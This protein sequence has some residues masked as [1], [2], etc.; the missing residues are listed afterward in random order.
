[1]RGLPNR[2][3]I[4]LSFIFSVSF[5]EVTL[6]QE[7][8]DLDSLMRYYLRSDSI[9]L[10]ELERLTSDSLSIL[11]LIDSLLAYEVRFSQISA[12]FGYTSRI[13]NA[14]RDL[15]INQ[16]GFR[17]AL[18]Y[19]HKSGLLG[20][21]SAFWNSDVTPK[22]NPVITT[23]GYL[24]SIQSKFSYILSYDHFFYS[25]GSSQSDQSI[26]Y[27]FNNALNGSV[28][29]DLKYV[30]PGVD[31]SF[32]FGEETAHRFGTY[33]TGNIRFKNLS[34]GGISVLPTASL[35]F[36]NQTIYYQNINFQALRIA[37]Q[38]A[39]R[40]GLT[41]NDFDQWRQYV[42][43]EGQE[44]V[45]GLMNLSLSLPVYIHLEKVNLL[46]NYHLNIPQQ[47]PGEVIDVSPNS[48]V[49]VAIFYSHPFK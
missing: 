22:F 21:V 5:S 11:D 40:R 3:W 29:Y 10:D 46:F 23:L 8:E 38:I 33:L 12:R 44:N 41:L 1:M 15:G 30:T 13:L 31:Y 26:I 4:L 48:F 25:Q 17:G 43:E 6:A 42:F 32:L 37:Q 36:G 18:S 45:F 27:S 49:N 2:C 47:L 9:L 24:G 35:L 16:Y 34:F 14:G 28:Y 7:E 20:E 39:Q 19:Y